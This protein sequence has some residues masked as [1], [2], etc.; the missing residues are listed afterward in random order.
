MLAASDF[1]ANLTVTDLIS[2][3]TLA[4]SSRYLRFRTNGTAS[5]RSTD[6]TRSAA[7]SRLLAR[8]DQANNLVAERL[9]R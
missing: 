9:Y 5:F 2:M 7:A 6:L 3:D 8:R 4:G 1:R